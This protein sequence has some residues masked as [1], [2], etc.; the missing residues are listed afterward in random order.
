[1]NLK[2]EC[3]RKKSEGKLNSGNFAFNIYQSAFIF[4]H[5][6]MKFE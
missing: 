3:R 6:K 4:L 1:M 2:Y 5:L